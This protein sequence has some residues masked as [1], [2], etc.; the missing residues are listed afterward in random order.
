[1]DLKILREKVLSDTPPDQAFWTCH[2]T[3][4]RNIYELCRTIKA[5]SNESFTYHVNKD[6]QKNDYAD[7]I[8]GVL[9]DEEL[10]NRLIEVYDKDLYAD[11]IQ[12]RILEF[13]RIC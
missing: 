10:A 1:M 2:G 5:Q 4:C 7:W 13:E 8:R 6:N 12:Q 11:I 9:V 3:V